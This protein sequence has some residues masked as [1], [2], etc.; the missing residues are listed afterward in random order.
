LEILKPA[1]Q[2]QPVIVRNC[3]RCVDALNQP[4]ER[5]QLTQWQV[6]FRQGVQLLEENDDVGDGPD[7]VWRQLLP[8]RH[9][10]PAGCYRLLQVKD[11]CCGHAFGG[12]PAGELSLARCGGGL[13]GPGDSHH[14]S[15]GQT[16]YGVLGDPYRLGVGRVEAGC[17]ARLLKYDSGGRG[18]SSHACTVAAMR[19]RRSLASGRFR[20]RPANR[21]S[22]RRSSAARQEVSLPTSS[23]AR[24]PST[25]ACR[26]SSPLA[27]TREASF[28]SEMARERA[29]ALP[30]PFTAISKRRAACPGSWSA[31]TARSNS[32]WAVSP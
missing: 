2:P 17:E 8:E 28:V 5:V 23:S 30:C 20:C 6:W 26:G 18:R 16:P 13:S 24:W 14:H 4:D 7:R 29:K 21:A 3:D 1:L 27:M 32:A 19:S 11:A 31:W 10:V 25:T 12:Q 22:S 15:P 9:R